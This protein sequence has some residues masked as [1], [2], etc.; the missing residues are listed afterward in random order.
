MKWINA[1]IPI[2]RAA[3]FFRNILVLFQL[4][5]FPPLLWLSFVSDQFLQIIQDI[6]EN[7]FLPIC[8]FPSYRNEALVR[9]HVQSI[10]S[11]FVT[12]T[13][14]HL[15]SHVSHIQS[16][17]RCDLRRFAKQRWSILLP[18]RNKLI[19]CFEDVFPIKHRITLITFPL[20][21]AISPSNRNAVEIPCLSPC[22]ENLA[23][24]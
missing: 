9:F 17:C 11:F 8:S 4:G 15:S 12:K 21:T 6:F 7:D 1:R 19:D 10:Q 23:K 13:G 16:R 14:L 3:D 5:R 2:T 20:I 18:W 22:Q 24:A